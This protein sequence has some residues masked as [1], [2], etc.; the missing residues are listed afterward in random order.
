[1]WKRRGAVETMSDRTH[2]TLA[3]QAVTVAFTPV[4]DE[5]GVAWPRRRVVGGVIATIVL[6]VIA[7]GLLCL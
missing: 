5:Y 2:G 3:E 6:V 4:G 7:A 1:M